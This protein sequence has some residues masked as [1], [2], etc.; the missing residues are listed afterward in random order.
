MDTVDL[1][2]VLALDGSASVGFDEF[3]LILNGCAGGL[4]DPEVVSGLVEGPSKASL[5]CVVLWSGRQM[6][7]SSRSIRPG[8]TAIGA[9]L[10]VCEALLKHVPAP[11]RR[12]V[13]DVAGDGRSN[14]GPPPAPIRD[15]LAAAN[16]TI[17][18]LCVLHDEADLVES[19]MAEV[20]GGPDAFAV[21]CGDFAGFAEAM[22]RKLLRETQLVTIGARPAES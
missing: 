19:Y 18:G 17:N 11:P 9:A 13:I 12:R 1:A 15:R 6:E 5:L 21:R 7:A 8:T 2:L 10:L 4:R 22:R 3:G 20:V 16:V 14:D